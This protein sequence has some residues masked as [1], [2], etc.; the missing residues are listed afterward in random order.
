M[1][2]KVLKAT[3]ICSATAMA[4]ASLFGCHIEKESTKNYSKSFNDEIISL[5]VQLPWGEIEITSTNED[6]ASV[7]AQN[8]PD[9]FFAEVN[10]GVLKFT[11]SSDN[12]LN[13]NKNGNDTHITLKLPE[14]DYSNLK[15][16]LSSGNT[17]IENIK[18]NN[19][20]INCNSGNINI[21]TIKNTDLKLI[22]ECGNVNINNSTL[23]NI[24]I[25]ASA[26]KINLEL[27]NSKSD[28]FG[29]NSKYSLNIKNAS[30]ET[31]VSYNN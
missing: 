30:G 6:R 18:V 13:I 29:D 5:D 20:D 4:V 17:T 16:D 10:N 27:T 12:K 24:D 3:L 19:I 9:G 2:S 15:L 1:F 21:S 7:D 23:G 11:F 25:T 28:Y 26:S 22:N 31:N 8:V 14:K